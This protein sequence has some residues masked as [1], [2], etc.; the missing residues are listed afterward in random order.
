[1]RVPAGRGGAE[2]FGSD[3]VIA[4][5]TGVARPSAVID[6]TRPSAPLRSRPPA[7]RTKPFAIF[8]LPVSPHS[9]L[10]ER[11]DC[12]TSQGS[13][14][15]RVAEGRDSPTVIAED[16]QASCRAI[17]SGRKDGELKKGSLDPNMHKVS[18]ARELRPEEIAAA[19]DRVLRP[20]QTGARSKRGVQN[21]AA[22]LAFLADGSL[23]C[24]CSAGTNS[25]GVDGSKSGRP[26][27]AG[28]PEYDR[29]GRRNFV[30]VATVHEESPIFAAGARCGRKGQ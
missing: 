24:V 3:E 7:R 6:V 13:K 19:M 29:C 11:Q 1:M 27:K 9:A 22:N 25:I 5:L 14:A 15:R 21:H 4:S 17:E 18:P 12:W 26:E 28:K 8:S 30:R 10:G 20:H 2:H 23:A 16:R